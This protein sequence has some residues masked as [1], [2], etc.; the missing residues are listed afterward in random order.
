MGHHLVAAP[1]WHLVLHI[2]PLLLHL[3]GAPDATLPDLHED[4]IGSQKFQGT[5]DEI[6]V[7]FD[8]FSQGASS[9][10]SLYKTGSRKKKHI[11]LQDSQKWE[12]PGMYHEHVVL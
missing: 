5:P 4:A 2:R 3:L 11:L 6:V 9:W 7:A 1:P 12:F 10:I 8:G